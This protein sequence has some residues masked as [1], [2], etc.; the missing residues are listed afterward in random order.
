MGEPISGR[1]PEYFP[2]V[3]MAEIGRKNEPLGDPDRSLP[4]DVLGLIGTL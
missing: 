2:P 3:R 1:L 4:E